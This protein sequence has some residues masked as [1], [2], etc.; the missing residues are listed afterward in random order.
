MKKEISKT[1][2][3][4]LLQRVGVQIRR[5]HHM[6]YDLGALLLE[7]QETGAYKH[8]GFV[9]FEE[10]LWSVGFRA[11]RAYRFIRA[12]KR[13]VRELEIPRKKLGQI[14]ESKVV[15][16]VPVV[17]KAN[18]DKWINIAKGCTC[19]ELIRLVQRAQGKTPRE[20]RRI[21]FTVDP[22]D[23]HVINIAIFKVQREYGFERVGD[24]LAMLAKE[25]L[26]DREADLKQAVAIAKKAAD[27]HQKMLKQARKK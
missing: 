18:V 12:H 23:E 11:T 19:K 2:A 8:A 10:W 13:F 3:L 14:E 24:A 5:L 22:E 26:R 16:L 9:N 20:E 1:K 7:V 4:R 17:T 27:Q 6:I 21:A 15:T 25:S